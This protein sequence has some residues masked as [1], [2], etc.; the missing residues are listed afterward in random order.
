MNNKQLIHQLLS[1]SQFTPDEI[2]R[3]NH[4]FSSHH[5]RKGEFILSADSVAKE[6]HFIVD[7]LVRTFYSLNGKEITTYIA[8]DNGF[9]SSYS[10]FIN[11]TRSF[12]YIQCLESS[13]TI[14]ITYNKMESLYQEIPSWE[15][16][17][18]I[19][20]EKNYLCMADRVLKLQMIPAKEKYLNFL[21]TSEPKIIQRTPLIHV[22]SFLGITSESLSRIRKSIS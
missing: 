7:G 21:Q 19:L 10:S 8:C 4:S 3:I 9:I 6:I 5:F 17:G 1:I 2:E 11:Q 13:Q 12:E 15:K 16:V 18:R 22:A 14:S 20:A